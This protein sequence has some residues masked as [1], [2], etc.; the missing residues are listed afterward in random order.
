MQALESQSLAVFGGS[1]LIGITPAPFKPI[2]DFFVRRWCNY[3]S[4]RI[5]NICSPFIH[6]RIET[7]IKA[8]SDVK[9]NTGELVSNTLSSDRPSSPLTIT[10]FSLTSISLFHL[11]ERRIAVDHRR[12]H[13]TKRPLAALIKTHLRPS[14][15]HQQSH[16]AGYHFHPTAPTSLPRLFRSGRWI[17]RHPEGRVQISSRGHRW[18]MDIGS[19]PKAQTLGFCAS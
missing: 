2:V 17:C 18:E 6:G 1:T 14:H 16:T 9:S 8:G 3:Y 15:N 12:I 4:W 19:A 10:I 7:T 13:L 5:N 11:T